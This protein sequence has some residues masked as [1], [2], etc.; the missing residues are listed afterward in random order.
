[1]GARLEVRLFSRRAEVDIP[2]GVDELVVELPPGH[3]DPE[4]EKRLV[5]GRVRGGETVQLALERDDAV[6]VSAVPS[7]PWRP[8]P[9]VR[10]ALTEGRD[11]IQPLAR[12]GRVT[13]RS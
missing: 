2:E 7:P 12:R 5:D 11:R 13:A 3:G 10:R 9:L 1:D 8:W 4:R 6:D